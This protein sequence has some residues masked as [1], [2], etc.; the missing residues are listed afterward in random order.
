VTRRSPR[1]DKAPGGERTEAWREI[2]EKILVQFREELFLVVFGFVAGL[3][4]AMGAQIESGQTGLRFTF[5]RAGRVLPH[6]FHPLIPFLQRVRRIPTRSRTLDL[7]TQRVATFEGLVYH[8]DANLVYRVIDVRKA[9]IEID[10]LEKGMLQMLGLGVQEILRAASREQLQ[11]GE[12]LDQN[13]ATNLARRLAPWGVE[14]ERAGFGSI[15]P[16]PQTLRIT[17]LGETVRE[18]RT[19]HARLVRA[20]VDPRRAL[21]LVGTRWMPRQRVRTLRWRAAH[22]KRLRQLRALLQ[23]AGWT[24]VEVKQ[25]ELSLRSRISVKGRSR[26]AA[27]RA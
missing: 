19:T 24:A 5:G 25:A 22:T 11:T 3:V 8:V 9:L 6:G 13:L 20:G 15:S 21:A 23:Q 18:R 2:I 26:A 27:R 12:G 1:Q 16:S 4:R 7:A 17:Q 10:E 14:V